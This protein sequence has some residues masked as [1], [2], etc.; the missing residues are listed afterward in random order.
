M[1][2]FIITSTQDNDDN[3]R[4]FVK[5]KDWGSDGGV[6]PIF[7]FGQEGT[8]NAQK[9][10]TKQE[11]QAAL[12]VLRNYPNGDQLEIVTYSETPDLSHR[13]AVGAMLRKVRNMQ[14]LSQTQLGN[15]IGSTPQYVSRYESGKVNLTLDS[16]YQI[17]KALD[18]ALDFHLKNL[19]TAAGLE[20]AAKIQ[21]TIIEYDQEREV[22]IVNPTDYQDCLEAILSSMPL[23]EHPEFLAINNS[24][25][26][27][28]HFLKKYWMKQV[29]SDGECVADYHLDHSKRKVIMEK[30]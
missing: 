7:S 19:N 16:L 20:D 4:F 18:Y 9:F 17:A 24:E 8:N 22:V 1:T 30:P 26:D 21:V 12:D 23:N 2:Q 13:Q 15:R 14:G 5:F 27:K 29:D 3:T 6:Q 28:N 11:A 25:K 10:N